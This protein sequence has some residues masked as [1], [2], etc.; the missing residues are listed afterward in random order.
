MEEYRFSAED[1][2]RLAVFIQSAIGENTLYARQIDQLINMIQDKC[3][4][5][6]CELLRM[7]VAF[8]E[9]KEKVSKAI[10]SMGK[11][12]HVDYR[13]IL[14]DEGI[15]ADLALSKMQKV[16]DEI[17]NTAR[18]MQFH[19]YTVDLALQL[20]KMFTEKQFGLRSQE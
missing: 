5:D 2:L 3:S 12:K 14:K 9:Y 18:C 13:R 8:T 15:K 16:H 7:Q 19:D 11:R 10:V 20:D 17:A 4:D 6:K 1:R